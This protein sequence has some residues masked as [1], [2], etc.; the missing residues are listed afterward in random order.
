MNVCKDKLLDSPS[1][2]LFSH[3]AESEREGGRRYSAERLRGG[4]HG[5][6]GLYFHTS[7]TSTLWASGHGFR[8]CISRNLSELGFS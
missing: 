2:A 1:L 5:Q 8:V 7:F 3:R 4:E 6:C